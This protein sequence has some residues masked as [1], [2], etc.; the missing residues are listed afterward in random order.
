MDE[1]WTETIWPEI[2]ETG[3]RVKVTLEPPRRAAHQTHRDNFEGD[4]QQYFKR[5][6]CI[7]A[8]D[9]IIKELEE[10]FGP[11][12]VMVSRLLGLYPSNLISTPW[13]ELVGDMYEVLK[14]FSKVIIQLMYKGF[15]LTFNICKDT[16]LITILY[17]KNL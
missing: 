11:K 15:F 13:E 8:I 9:S 1:E 16:K 2:Q 7:P 4:S 6:V 17:C 10:R 5:T 14:H 12:Q 3:K